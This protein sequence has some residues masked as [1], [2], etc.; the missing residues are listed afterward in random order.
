MEK[1]FLRKNAIIWRQNRVIFI[2]MKNINILKFAMKV[3][4]LVYI[5]VTKKKTIA[6]HVLIILYLNQI[7]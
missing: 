3:V 4:R 7:Y 1:I 6:L 5:M 2:L